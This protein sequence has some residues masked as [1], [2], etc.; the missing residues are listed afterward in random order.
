MLHFV[1]TFI[2]GGLLFL[3]PLVVVTAVVGKAFGLVLSATKPVAQAMSV[4]SI[5][6]VAVVD[7]IA[8]VLLLLGC[9]AA[10]F[11][12]QSAVGRKLYH[13]VDSNLE[14]VLPGY[15]TLK[16]RLGDAV[17]SEERRKTLRTV[18][19]RFDDQ[20]QI[21]FEVERL[22]DGRVTV[23]LPGA[24]DPWSGTVVVVDADRVAPV[25]SDIMGAARTFK[26]LGWGT[27][28]ALDNVARKDP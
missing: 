11:L 17:G 12:A 6:G 14:G 23:F 5:A 20:A 13:A 24:P 7:A 22:A 10:G 3:F 21:A 26:N 18:F 8:M 9:F 25:D 1:K 15:A 28:A 19:V 4:E 2:I 16:A 27:A